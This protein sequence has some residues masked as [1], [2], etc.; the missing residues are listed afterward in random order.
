[1]VLIALGDDRDYAYA[2]AF[3]VF[4]VAAA[5][6]F[7]DGYLARRW[8][9]TSTLGAFLDTMADKLL[10]AGALLALVAVDRVWVWAAFVIVGREIVMMGLRGVAALEGAKVPPSWLGKGKAI[11]QFVAIGLAIV[12]LW[13]PWGPFYLDEWAMLAAVGITVWSGVHYFLNF[14]RVLRP[15]RR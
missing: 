7:V 15:A 8:E 5:S 12:R 9:V 11:A 3:V 10:V 2:A 6:D 14:A 1:M 13:E 4:V